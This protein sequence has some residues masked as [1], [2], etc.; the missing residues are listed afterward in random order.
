MDVMVDLVESQ[1]KRTAER[2]AVLVANVITKSESSAVRA[3]RAGILDKLVAALGDQDR[4]SFAV[5]AIS[6]FS[7]H[8]CGR[9][10]L[11]TKGVKDHI[12][13]LQK[14]KLDIVKNPAQTILV[15]LES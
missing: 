10:H 1:D 9:K 8:E 13:K 4:V 3:V 2:A 6:V 11:R 5:Q 7:S 12:Q 14:S 15:H